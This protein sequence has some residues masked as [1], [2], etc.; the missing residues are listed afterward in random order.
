MKFLLGYNIKLIIF[1]QLYYLKFGEGESTGGI[2]PGGGD[3]KIL[4]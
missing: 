1:Y 3:E 4:S 2:F